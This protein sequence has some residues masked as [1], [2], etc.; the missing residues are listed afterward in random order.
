[1]GLPASLGVSGELWAPERE[2]RVCEVWDRAGFGEA[3]GWMPGTCPFSVPGVP[4]LSWHRL[5]PLGLPP[6]SLGLGKGKWTLQALG[7][8][9]RVWSFSL[10]GLGALWDPDLGAPENTRHVALFMSAQV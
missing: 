8:R 7:S 1:M 5:A 6:S 10:R 9:K 2:V 4:A 3:G